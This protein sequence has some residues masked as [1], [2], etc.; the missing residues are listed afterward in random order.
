MKKMVV[1]L[2]AGLL[3]ASH[4][5]Y[6]QSVSIQFAA[7]SPQQAYAAS[8]L[9]KSASTKGHAVKKTGGEY[10]INFVTE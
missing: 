4:F 10:V 7:G 1:C 9:E 2:L 8:V 5:L 3:A 6:S